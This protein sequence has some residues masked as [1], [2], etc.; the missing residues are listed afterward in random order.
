MKK[1]KI[2]GY[3][4]MIVALIIPIYML[5]SMSIDRFAPNKEY[6]NY[7]EKS[8]GNV[9]EYKIIKSKIKDYNKKLNEGDASIV[10]PFSTEDY[11]PAYDFSENDEDFILGYVKI[12]RLDINYPLKLGT[13][14]P[15]IRYG[16]GHVDGTSLPD[17]GP[18]TRSVIASHRVTRT[19]LM[20]YYINEIQEGDVLLLD[21]GY[22]VIKYKYKSTEVIDPSE[23]EKLLPVENE[24]LITILTCDP[25][26]PPFNKR[27]L[28]SF[29]KEEELISKESN[30]KKEDNKV[31]SEV[32]SREELTKF[33]DEE[34]LPKDQNNANVQVL[35]KVILAVAI[36]LW[37][38][39]FILIVRF[40]KLLKKR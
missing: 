19:A 34:K 15:N 33:Y 31:K 16:F 23:W 8:K 1:R 30:I 13:T 9:Q 36:I 24:E 26:V 22:K 37:L 2:L 18:G 6:S 5:T 20:L 11:K 17:T 12:P 38:L 28:V 25:P 3:C 7:A 40:I 4:L 39:L 14:E 10:D 35:P 27:I 32:V 29:E 21:L